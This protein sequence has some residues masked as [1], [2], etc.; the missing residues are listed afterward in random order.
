MESAQMNLQNYA[1][2][3]ANDQ[4]CI[5]PGLSRVD[6][7]PTWRGKWSVVYTTR[8]FQG[9]CATYLE[10]QMISGVYNQ[11]FPGWMRH[12]PGGANDQ[13][14]IQP[15]LS[16]VDAP[17]TWRG[18]WSVVYTTRAFQDGCA[19]YLEGQMISG[20]YNQGFP[21]WMRHLPG[22][23]NDQWCIQPGLSRVD[24]PPTWRGK[25]SVV[26][27]TRAF[28]GGCPTH[29][30]DQIEDVN[31][32]KWKK[33]IE[34]KRTKWRNVSLSPTQGWE[35]GYAPANDPCLSNLS[36]AWKW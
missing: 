24:A 34:K 20:V 3:W 9:G 36:P 30:E 32:E 25:W 23:A 12:L 26:Y 15:G 22:G 7:P 2:T 6:A 18:K 16:R 17:P 14:C 33:V 27:T 13:W 35:S 4:W 11:G 29:L 28:Q 19:T 21:G 31:E 1:S 5:Q 8:A 10:G